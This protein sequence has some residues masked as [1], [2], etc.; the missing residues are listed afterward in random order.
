[1]L[2]NY[3]TESPTITE[4]LASS[5]TSKS[6]TEVVEDRVMKAGGFIVEWQSSWDK[7]A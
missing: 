4:K 1:M 3:L 6:K 2:E 5:S 7:K